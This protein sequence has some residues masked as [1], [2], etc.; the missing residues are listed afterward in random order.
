[1]KG[2]VFTGNRK[3]ELR[4][5]EDP[6]PGDDEV[7]IEIKASGMCGSDLH[8]Y[9]S[10]N[11]GD[12]IAGHEPCGVVVARGR[13]VSEQAAPT[14][15]RVMV[16]H[17]DGCRR[18]NNCLEGWTQLCDEGSTVFGRSAH[19]A[20]A[21][22]Q[23]IP[24]RTLVPLPDGLAFEEGAAISCGTGT[25]YGAIRRMEMQAGAKVAVYGQGPVG[26]SATMLAA[27]MGAEVY[28]VDIDAGRLKTA[29]TFGAA[30]LVDASKDDPVSAIKEL[31]GGLGADYVIECSGAPEASSAAVQSAKTWGTV[32][33]VGIGGP[34]TYHVNR[35]IIHKQL[36][37]HGSWTF[38]VTGQADCARY[39]AEKKLPVRD[40]FT[41][42]FKLDDAVAAY[43]LFDTQTTGKAVIFPS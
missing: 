25:A 32:C 7:V 27:S 5:F 9:R 11:P 3:L 35:D 40:L 26:L 22:Y 10:E 33:F 28:A 38:S 36:T 1:M 13:S 21:R 30:S 18:C 8:H 37:L 6:T 24:A 15:A 39:V 42:S 4:N 43:E 41:H 31:S 19:G 20:H 29:G 17:Y 2:V 34:A 16:H 23:K 12:N 14:D